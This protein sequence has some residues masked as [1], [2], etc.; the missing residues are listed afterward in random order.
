MGRLLNLLIVVHMAGQSAKM[1]PISAADVSYGVK[2]NEGAS[3]AI[4]GHYC[5]AAVGS[6]F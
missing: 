3:H 2:I 4:G 5:D 1:A 6:C